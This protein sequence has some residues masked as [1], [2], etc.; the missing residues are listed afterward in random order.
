V[1]HIQD[2]CVE[3]PG[4]CVQDVNLHIQPGEFFTLIG[5]T[6]SG[7]TVLLENWPG[8]SRRRAAESASVGGT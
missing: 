6:G 2:V 1:I 5:P 3:L 7:K 4:F 8:L